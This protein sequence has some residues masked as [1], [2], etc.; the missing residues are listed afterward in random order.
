MSAGWAR[1]GVS[2][3]VPDERARSW[4][5]KKYRGWILAVLALAGCATTSQPPVPDEAMASAGK[6][7]LATLTRGHSV[8]MS[9]CTRC[10][11]AKM[12]SEISGEDWHVVVPG[13]AWNASISQAD[14][15]AVLA[16]ILAARSV[17]P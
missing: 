15:E 7:D 10:H 13:M 2:L 4:W 14:E 3:L 5:M 6:S 16:Y 17:A 1:E 11:E 8:Y 12:P 9:Q